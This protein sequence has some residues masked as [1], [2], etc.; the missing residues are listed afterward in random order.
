MTERPSGVA[1]PQPATPKT[2]T[3]STWREALDVVMS[4]GNLRATVAVAACVGTMLLV[5]NQLDAVLQGRIGLGLL[6]KAVLTYVVPF[7]VSNYGVL[8]A[9]RRRHPASKE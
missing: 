9:T 6:F 3:W 5:I 4:R 8:T 7:L 2:G 1:R